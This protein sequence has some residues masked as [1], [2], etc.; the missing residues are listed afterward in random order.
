MFRKGRIAAGFFW[1]TYDRSKT[2]RRHYL[3]VGEGPRIAECSRR[4]PTIDRLSRTARSLICN[5]FPSL[6]SLQ[7]AP[8][9]AGKI[10]G[11]DSSP[12]AASKHRSAEDQRGPADGLAPSVGLLCELPYYWISCIILA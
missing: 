12:T 7:F 11:A 2:V 9:F 1:N 4:I 5:T 3:H 8:S 10:F 6:F